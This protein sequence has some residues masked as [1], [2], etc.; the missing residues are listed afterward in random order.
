MKKRT[1]KIWTID[2][3]E[4]QSIIDKSKSICDVL[5]RLGF[6]RYNGNHR[7]LTKRIKEDKLCLDKM[8]D[9]REKHGIR[10]KIDL[11]D[12]LTKNSSYN[13]A[14]LKRRLVKETLLEY[15]CY[16]P[17]VEYSA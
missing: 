1:S 12:I 11:V 4:L 7:T 14:N 16:V 9:N 10:D 5:K 2:R 8:N 6:D 15:K 17:N 3:K 13:R